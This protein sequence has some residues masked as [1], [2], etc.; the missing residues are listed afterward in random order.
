MDQ[1]LAE[2]LNETMRILESIVCTDD[3]D[4]DGDGGSS[5]CQEHAARIQEFMAARSQP[6]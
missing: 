4:D 1:D 2:L 5:V 3:E 6:N